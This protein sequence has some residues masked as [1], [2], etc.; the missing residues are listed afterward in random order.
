MNQTKA[1]VEGAIIVSIFSVILLFCL[2]VP[3]LAFI[4]YLAAPIP[5]ILYTIRYGLKNG[6]A[7]GAIGIVISILIGSIAGLLNAPV[8]VAV[9]IAMGVFY[10]KKQ[11]RNAIISGA[12]VYLVSLLV[13]YV[14]SV[15]FFQL[16]IMVIAKQ[17]IEETLPMVESLLKQSG[18]SEKEIAA[19]LKRLEEF[20]ETAK[21][22]LPITIIIGSVLGA[23]LNH[24]IAQPFLKR[25]VSDMPSLQKFK[26]IRLPKSMVW[27]YL[28]TLLLVF[29]NT[30]KDSF[31]WLVQTSAYYVLLLLVLIQGFSFIFYYCYEKKISRAVPIFVIVFTILLPQIGILVRILGIVDIGF[32]L[33]DKIKNK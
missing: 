7:A 5:I 1:I 8:M 24:W 11:P 3:L 19:Q 18:A 29:I 15:Q 16:D 25:F 6:L 32:D 22:I 13:Y 12:F 31:L 30:E 17:T 20:E 10:R 28:F 14:V 27:Y 26:D 23:I 2:Y 33:R 21:S 9:G 4:F